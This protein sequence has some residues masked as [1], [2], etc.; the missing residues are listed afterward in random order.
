MALEIKT[1]ALR[2][3]GQVVALNG[4]LDTDGAQ[5]LKAEIERLVAADSPLV[6]LDLSGLVYLNSQGVRVLQTSFRVMERAG[7]EMKLINPTAA[8]EQ[9]LEIVR[10]DALSERFADMEALDA[11]LH[12]VQ[13]K[14]PPASES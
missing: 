2:S 7:G 5:L 3:F 6:V 14:T 11:Y 12:E 8:V 4:S 10:M 9:V 1:T 13:T